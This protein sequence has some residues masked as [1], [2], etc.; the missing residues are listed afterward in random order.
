MKKLFCTMLALLLIPQLLFSGT[1]MTLTTPWSKGEAVRMVERSVTLH[2]ENGLVLMEVEDSF[3][4]LSSVQCE[5]LYRFTLP[6][7]AFAAGFWI[8]TDGKEWVKGEVREINEAKQIYHKITSRLVDPGL[9]EQKD[10]EIVIRVFPVE[11]SARVGI[12]F[13]CYFPAESADGNY[14]FR[15]PLSYSSSASENNFNQSSEGNINFRLAATFKDTQGIDGLS[16]NDERATIDAS[17]AEKNVKLEYAESGLN[18]VELSYSLQNREKVAMAFYQVPEGKRFSLLR[19]AGNELSSADRSLRLAVIIDASGSMGSLN[20]ARALAL[21]DKL[22][23][24]GD[25]S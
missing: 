17:G 1:T 4:N 15:L 20:R 16:C 22:T 13:R 7:G 6:A 3:L 11:R 5:G 8:N 10:G 12:R 2:G 21:C 23:T 18:D 24:T 19:I 25:N 9:L 14:Q